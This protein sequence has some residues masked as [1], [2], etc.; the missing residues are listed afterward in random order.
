MPQHSPSAV[1]AADVR[2][3]YDAVFKTIKL[4]VKFK[5][6]EVV[7]MSPDWAFARTNSTG[8]CTVLASGAKSA[9][10][11]QELFIFKKGTYGA[12][13]IARY[14]FCTTNPPPK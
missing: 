1:G 8:T 10:G 9:E 7:V 13:K 12:W 14:C 6:A 4:Q 2:K 11:N 5:V 3:A